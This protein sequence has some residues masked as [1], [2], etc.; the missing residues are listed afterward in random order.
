MKLKCDTF[1]V[2]KNFGILG[3]ESLGCIKRRC[4]GLCEMMTK[5]ISIIHGQFIKDTRQLTRKGVT[6]RLFTKEYCKIDEYLMNKSE[7]LVQQY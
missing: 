1:D 4:I 6:Q 3:Y 2:E 7:K 5:C